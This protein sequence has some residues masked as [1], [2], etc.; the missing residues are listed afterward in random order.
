VHERAGRLIVVNLT[1]TYV[2]DVADVVI[3]GDMAEVLPLIARACA[4][5]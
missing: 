5:G 4:G 3:H 1:P 2:D